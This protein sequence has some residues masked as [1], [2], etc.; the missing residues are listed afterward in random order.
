MDKLKRMFSAHPE[1]VGETYFEH[2][3]VAFSFGFELMAA[4]VACMLHGV[5]PFLCEKT[6][7]A[8]IRELN[9]RMVTHRD[10][11]LPDSARIPAE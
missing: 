5:F 4:A 11:R 1:S 6:A 7:S 2:L 3:G 10:K 9:H 8:K